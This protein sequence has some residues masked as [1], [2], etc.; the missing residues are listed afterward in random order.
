[1]MP[2]CASPQHLFAPCSPMMVGAVRIYLNA[3][4]GRRWTVR[5][6]VRY[7]DLGKSKV[8]CDDPRCPAGGPYRG[9]FSNRLLMGLVGTSLKF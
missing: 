4:F 8:S 7:F 5:V 3:I 1:M 6:E 9:E 2:F